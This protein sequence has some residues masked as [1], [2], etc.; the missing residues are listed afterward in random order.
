MA[1]IL[2]TA[3]PLFPILNQPSSA[4]TG[5]AR[6]AFESTHADDGH[7]IEFRTLKVRSI[8]NRIQSKRMTWMAWGINPYRGCEFACRYCYARYT[9]EFMAPAPGKPQFPT[10]QA[11]QPDFHDPATFERLIF[12][13]QNAAWLLDQELRRHHSYDEIAIGTATDP[14]QPVERRAR[15][16][17]SLLDV[18][19]RH[20][21]LR[22]GVVTKSRLILRDT[23][24]LQE[25]HRRNHLV[26]HITITTPDAVLARLLEPRAP[27]PDLRFDT[28]RRL[29]QAGITTGILCSPLLPGITDTEE[30]IDRMAGLAAEVNASFFTANPLFLKPC[31]RPTYLSFVREHFPHLVAD[32]HRRFDHADFASRDYALHLSRLVSQ[33]RERHGLNRRF[34]DSADDTPP[35]PAGAKKSPH[36][37]EGPTQQRL[38]A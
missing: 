3:E 24:L 30:A 26:V 38:F 8:L 18:F 32:Y 37:T 16:T 34:S 21:G 29:R 12:L 5:I 6:M 36:R 14:W 35:N 27:R 13:K 20:A 33:A 9:H 28:V 25:I 7:L 2:P 17:R 4:P 15:I 31:S 22:I 19:A 1:K 10:Q 23:D 11:N